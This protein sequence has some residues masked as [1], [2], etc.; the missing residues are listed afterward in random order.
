M[1]LQ[2]TQCYVPYLS[3]LQLFEKAPQRSRLVAYHGQCMHQHLSSTGRS[4]FLKRLG[5]L[6]WQLNEPLV[7]EP[8]LLSILALL[9]LDSSS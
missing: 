2:V 3:A 8:H 9:L 4:L 5:M 1:S 7:L 6:F